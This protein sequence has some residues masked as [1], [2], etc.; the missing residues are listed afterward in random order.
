MHHMTF[1]HA[2]VISNTKHS[3]VFFSV[4]QNDL[5]I[6]SQIHSGKTL[7]KIM[8]LFY[9]FLNDKRIHLLNFIMTLAVV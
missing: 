3:A 4:D 1:E 6:W 9:T 5:S 8:I 2:L 7:T